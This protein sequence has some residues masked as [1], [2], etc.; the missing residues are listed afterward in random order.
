[1]SARDGLIVALPEGAGLPPLWMR[2]VD[3]A[4]VQTGAGANWLAAC[5]LAELPSADRVMLVTPVAATMLRWA[6]HPDLPARQGR[7]VARMEALRE[8]ILPA[9][10]LFAAVDVNEDP[11]TPHLVG[12]TARADLTHWLLWAQHHGLD[13]DVIVPA[14]LLLPQ[15]EEGFSRG[16]IAGETVLRGVDMALPGD[17]ASM[18]GDAPVR[19]VPADQV[20]ARAVAALTAP[21]LDL[22][23][24]EF[25]KRVRR[26]W[27]IAALRRI[28]LWCGVILLV[29][30]VISLT[31]IVK[32]YAAAS[33]LDEQSLTLAK[34]VLP[35]ATDAE[36]AQAEMDR[37]LAARGA[38]THGFAPPVAALMTAM[39]NSPNVSLT[40]LSRDASGLVGATLASARAEDINAVLLA[41]QAAG[42]TITATSSQ[43]PSG[44]VLAQITVRS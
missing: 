9:D 30:L 35:Q 22:R 8:A 28:A 6:A 7:A 31:G 41:L 24:G 32:Q 27:D 10:Q 15:P 12:V 25:A 4:I 42:Y 18:V 1:M 23:Q 33:D 44:Q 38:G 3:G 2:V 19:D 26:E 37:L 43:A 21:P 29:S 11:A 5:G 14:S 34:Q 17:M 36:Q 16:L 40:A 39:Q 13:P 20:N